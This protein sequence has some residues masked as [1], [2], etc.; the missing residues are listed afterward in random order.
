MLPAFVA[1][2]LSSPDQS[3]K[4]PSAMDA[5]VPVATP[6][7]PE[8]DGVL[9]TLVA[10]TPTHASDR[11]VLSALCIGTF[12][13]SVVFVAPAPFFPVM[14]RDLGVGVPLLGQIIAAMLLLSALLGLIAGPLADRYGHR[15][16]IVLG[17]LATAVCL[18]LFGLAPMFPVLFAAALAGGLA[19]AAVLGPALAVAGTYFAGSA[20]RRALGWT[21]ACM[22]GS[23]IVGVPVLTALGSV[24]GWRAAFVAAGIG[25]VGA[26]WLGATW[27]PHDARPSE[28]RLRLQAVQD[29]YAPLLHHGPTLRL[30]AVSVLRAVCWYGLLTYFGAFLSQ[31]LGLSTSQVGLAYMLGGG[32]YFL[33]SLVAGGPLGRIPPRSL[34]VGGNVVMAL[35]MGL[36]FSAV[37]GPIGTVAVLPFAAL[38]GAFGWV[39][40]ASLL[41]AESP[42]GA[43]TTMTLH[44]SLFNLGAAAG[45]AIGGLLLAFA[46]YGALAIG[47]PIFGLGSALL[48]W[49]PGRR[50]FQS[51]VERTV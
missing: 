12:L 51:P 39:A 45:G 13:A 8:L 14:A 26:A 50:S 9:P 41:T 46:G 4:G 10:S 7:V 44:G 18:L 40:I 21:T 3:E 33:G 19:D 47:L 35:L 1:T 37:L 42:A 11:R 6:I 27:L 22:A 5:D 2:W 48:A 20:A 23:A 49:W 43:G 28:G 31:K 17:L 32:G 34:L 29:A 30:Y 24:V 36:A 16:L 25:A 38:A 15:L